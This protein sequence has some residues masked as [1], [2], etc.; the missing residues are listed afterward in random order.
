MSIRAHAEVAVKAITALII[1]CVMVGLM[2]MLQH[3][4][5]DKKPPKPRRD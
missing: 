4:L 2:Q 5:D 1:V 3:V